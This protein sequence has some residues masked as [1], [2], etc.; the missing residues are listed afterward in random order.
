MVPLTRIGPG[1]RLPLLADPVALVAFS[2]VPLVTEPSS[3]TC[4]AAQKARAS[5][6]SRS[7][8]V[9]I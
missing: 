1:P 3:S 7:M 9:S 5:I 2:T 8:D 6:Q 4:G